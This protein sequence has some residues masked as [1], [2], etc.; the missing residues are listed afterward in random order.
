MQL[1]LGW[2]SFG[3][4]VLSVSLAAPA[5]SIVYDV[6]TDEAFVEQA[7]V[8]VW[9]V[10]ERTSPA[11]IRVSTDALDRPETDALVRVERVLKGFVPGSE[12][13]VRQL[14]GRGSMVIGLPMLRAGDRVLLFLAPGA[15]GAWRTVDMGLGIFFED[16][17]HLFRHDVPEEGF[18]HAERFSRWIEDRGIGVV[19][20]ADYRVEEIPGPRQV[21]QEARWYGVGLSRHCG[22]PLKERAFVRWRQ[23][24]EGFVRGRGRDDVSGREFWTEPEEVSVAV[25]NSSD[26]TDERV[27][28]AIDSAA[29]MWNGD[30]LSRVRIPAADTDISA[31]TVSSNDLIGAMIR[32]FFG[33]EGGCA[34]IEAVQWTHEYNEETVPLFYDER[35]LSSG[36]DTWVAIFDEDGA[37]THSSS[38][39]YRCL[40]WG[41]TENC[42]PGVH[43]GDALCGTHEGAYTPQGTVYPLVRYQCPSNVLGY[44]K[45]YHEEY[46]RANSNHQGHVF[47][48]PRKPECTLHSIPGGGGQAWR[49]ERVDVWIYKQAL[50][51]ETVQQVLAHEL[52][53]ALGIDHPESGV[54]AIMTS[55][56]NNVYPSLQPDDLIAVRKLYP[57]VSSGSTPPLG[58]GAPPGGGGGAPA[59]EPEPEPE[60]PPPPP[61]VPPVASFSVD[62][63]CADGLCSARTGEDITFT[64]TSSGT[65]ARR[66]WDFET[67]GRTPSGRSVTHTWPSPGFY[68]ST[69]TVDGAGA[70]S[71]AS[72]MFR[73][74]AAE[75]AGS[76]VPGP[77]TACLQNSRFEVEVEWQGADGASN[78]A[79][80]VHAGTN[81]SGMFSFFDRSNWEVLIKVLDGCAANG[82]V[83]V[84]G[85]STTDLGYVIRVTDTATGVVKEYRNE[86]GTSAAAITDV[87]AFPDGCRDSP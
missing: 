20:P 16:R 25:Y 56:D 35:S 60:P 77:E 68:R 27:E 12:I 26:W 80:L 17:G 21:R 85:G 87:A 18:R 29:A 19:R 48:T 37:S 42:R 30:S 33:E 73:V 8:I 34:G 44:A 71:T 47:G 84:F 81:D 40:K 5:R 50:E 28:T 83:W 58:G 43:A 14:G 69:L 2:R 24:D 49:I 7:P 45:V 61:P 66:S 86:P 57:V 70:E 39:T 82:H 55:P 36:E 46:I 1:F 15:D 38:N 9:G 6:P 79:R 22:T 53:H 75:P 32:V 65:V 3:L 78:A 64:D 54:Q 4:V 59:S 52:G 23:W 10:V 76:C 13:V 67:N 31:R 62:M 74:D 63:P 41:D 72:R 51:R 11:P